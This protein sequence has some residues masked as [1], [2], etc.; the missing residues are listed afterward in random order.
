M[1]TG[2]EIRAARERAGLTQAE[3]GQLVGVSMRTIGNW[4]RG[5]TVSRNRLNM[6]KHVLATFVDSVNSD[7][8]RAATDAELLAEIARRFARGHEDK[9]GTDH[10]EAPNR[11]APGS[12]ATRKPTRLIRP[13]QVAEHDIQT[14]AAR[15]GAPD[16]APDVT[17]DEDSQ[18]PGSDDPA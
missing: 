10:D 6:L 16:Q 17:T 1:T 3:L 18:D 7:P 12:G 8:L 9:A 5:E 2:D 11:Q 14:W 4:E 13:D 15:P